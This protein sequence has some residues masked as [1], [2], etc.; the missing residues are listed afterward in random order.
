M[1]VPTFITQPPIYSMVVL[2]F[3]FIIHKLL[4]PPHTWANLLHV[5]FCSMHASWLQ[6]LQVLVA[7]QAQLNAPPPAAAAAAAALQAAA[8][9]AS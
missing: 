4:P 6:P 1:C 7:L 3:V 9:L 2:M 8:V 5:V